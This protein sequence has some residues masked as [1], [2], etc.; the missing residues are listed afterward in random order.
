[1]YPEPGS[2]KRSLLVRTND[3]DARDL[4]ARM[5]RFARAKLRRWCARGMLL[6]DDP[7]VLRAWR[8]KWDGLHYVQLQRWF[9]EG[10]RPKVVYDIG[11]NEGL[12][13]EMCQAIFAPEIS[14]LFEPQVEARD[15]A[16][17]RRARAGFD[18]RILPQ[19][20]GER[21]ERQVLHLT[22]NRAASSLLAPLVGESGGVVEIQEVGE[23]K[24]TVVPLDTLVVAKGLPQP[25]LIKIDVQ[26]FEGRVLAG[27]RKTLRGARRMVIEVSL[28]P[29]YAGQSLMPEVL[30]TVSGWGFELDDIQE[31]FRQWPGPLRQVDL[32]LRQKN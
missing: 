4:A 3:V 22:R 14:V 19:A 30:Q 7:R 9:D 2:A 21:E 26:G 11:A 20:L 18:W 28:Q 25:D 31:T 27:G 12:W 15:R 29:L 8:R 10:F 24:V 6:A 23:E 17:R 16:V 32:W 5:T 13:S 1:M